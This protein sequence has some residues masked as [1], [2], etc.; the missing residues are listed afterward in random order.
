MVDEP[1]PAAL[2]GGVALLERAI[3]YTLGCLHLVR[4]DALTRPTPCREWNLRALLRHLNDSLAALHEAVDVGRVDLEP[5][6]GIDPAVDPV[7]A[8]RA[9]AGHLLGAWTATGREL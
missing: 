4:P 7:A 3:T 2:A 8:L 1:A 5:V 6:T 9:R